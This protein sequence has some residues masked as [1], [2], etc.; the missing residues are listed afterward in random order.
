MKFYYCIAIPTEK[1]IEYLEE[2]LQNNCTARI[3][4]TGLLEGVMPDMYEINW[5]ETKEE[6]EKIIEKLRENR[7]YKPIFLDKEVWTEEPNETLIDPEAEQELYIT[8]YDDEL[9]IEYECLK[10]RSILE[11]LEEYPGIKIIEQR[12]ES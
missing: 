4:E 8:M 11:L 1:E 10:N 9:T 3:G 7:V 2:I 6:A 5:I 12:A